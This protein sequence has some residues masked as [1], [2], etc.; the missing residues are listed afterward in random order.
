MQTQ[1]AP[2]WQV[3]P[4]QQWTTQETILQEEV[5]QTTKDLLKEQTTKEKSIG[6]DRGRHISL[7]TH[8]SRWTEVLVVREMWTQGQMDQLPSHRTT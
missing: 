3:K 8:R 4:P 5:H 2:K 6:E 7:L 1:W